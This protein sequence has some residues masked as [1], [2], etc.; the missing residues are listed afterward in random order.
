MK[1]ELSRLALK[2]TEKADLVEKESA[3]VAKSLAVVRQC[4]KEMAQS[5]RRFEQLLQNRNFTGLLL[6][7]RNDELCL[8]Y[9]KSNIHEHIQKQGRAS[10]AGPAEGERCG[11][12]PKGSW[13]C[14]EKKTSGMR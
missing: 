1:A 2:W 7:D 4:E 11:D 3:K 8:L 14:D 9:E 5:R 6:I 12:G 13:M 10:V